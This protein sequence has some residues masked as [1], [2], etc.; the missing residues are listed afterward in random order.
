MDIA[1]IEQGELKAEVKF[2]KG[3]IVAIAALDAKGIKSEL[4]V[5]IPT[6]YFLDELAKAIPGTIDDSLIAVIKMALK[7]V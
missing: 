2:V 4:K 6:D 7:A 1:K 5:A 3:E